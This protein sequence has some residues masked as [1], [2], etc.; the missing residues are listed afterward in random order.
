[1]VSVLP[2]TNVAGY[3]LS[4][5]QRFLYIS[6][7]PWPKNYL[8]SLEGDFCAPPFMA[9]LHV[10]VLDLTRMEFCGEM[11]RANPP[12]WVFISGDKSMDSDVAKTV[13]CATKNFYGGFE[14]CQE[15]EAVLWDR[16]HGIPIRR[17]SEG[18][19]DYV[20]MIAVDPLTEQS[21]VTVSADG[22]MR[23]WR[24]IEEERRLRLL[25]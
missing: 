1:M 10:Q 20:C 13:S 6:V 4:P 7:H 3:C 2:Y 15:T 16:H 22:Q 24:S 14:S 23:V 5:D 17:F 9:S 8:D 21:V 19:E 12:T 11:Q 25:N 18:H